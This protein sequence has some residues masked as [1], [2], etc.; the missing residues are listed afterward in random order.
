MFA[1][2][3]FEVFQDSAVELKNLIEAFALHVGAGFFAA[4]AARAKHYDWLV[5]ELVWQL[6]D[7]TWEAPKMIH[8]ERHG[9]PKR[10]ELH[11]VVVSRIEQRDGSPLVEPAF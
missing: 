6:P 2:A 10:A 5:L 7:R 9:V 4:D 11:F 8:P 3:V 1:A